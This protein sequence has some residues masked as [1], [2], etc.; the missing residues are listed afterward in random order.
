VEQNLVITSSPHFRAKTTTRTIMTD[1]LIALLP[2]LIASVY[3]FGFRALLVS[4][5][6]AL[7][8]IVLE[9]YYQRF[10]KQQYTYLDMSA[11]V[12]GLLIAFNLPVTIPLWMAAIACFAAIVIVKQ[13]FGGLGK[14]F[15]NPA[16]VGRIVLLVS[17]AT[18]MTN[19]ALPRAQMG[20]T[21]AVTGATPLALTGATPMPEAMPSITDM[22]LGMIGGS[23]GETCKLTL[24]LGGIY[25]VIR[26]V[27]TPTTPLAFMGTVFVFSWALGEDPVYHLLAGGLILGAVFMAT[28]YVTTPTTEAGK[29]IFGVGCGLLTVL[30]RMWASYP[31][32]VSF[33]I[34]LM[35]ILTPHI[36]RLCRIKAFGGAR[37]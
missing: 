3:I 18:Q 8:C 21:E 9:A 23:L 33:A 24:L 30:I 35:N 32:G 34:L 5:F 1:V 14:N 28:D 26:R 25:L 22:F 2:T 13:L 17:F 12:T 20:L 31:E 19:W 7:L 36:D 4:V 37:A 6:C 10:T 11:A 27:I 29:V 15:A 16:I